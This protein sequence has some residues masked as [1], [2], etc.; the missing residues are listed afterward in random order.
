MAQWMSV[1]KVSE[2]Q[3]GKG[4]VV[5]AAGKPIALFNVGGSF[6]AIHNTCLH[7]GG[8]LGEGELEGN[9]VTCPWHGWQYDVTT[10][11]N[12]FNPSVGVSCFST[13]VEGDDVQVEV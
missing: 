12:L 10:G 1:A 4:R 5:E 13:R 7:R 6:Y 11:K 3:P 8:P 9:V 2:L